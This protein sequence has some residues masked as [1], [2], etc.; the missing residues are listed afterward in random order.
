SDGGSGVDTCRGTVENGA[1]VATADIGDATLSVTATDR[2]GNTRTTAA[3][4][5]VTYAVVPQYDDTQPVA[6][7]STMVITLQIADARGVN[8]SSGS[9]VV[10][11][12]ALSATGPEATARRMASPFRYDS[13][14]HEY[15][16]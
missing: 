13:A 7:G 3:A 1:A 8:R 4:Y 6:T 5:A 2:V 14:R 16:L 11:A 12:S 10:N 15:A 9:I